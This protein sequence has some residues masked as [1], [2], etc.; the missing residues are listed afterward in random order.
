MLTTTLLLTLLLA[1]PADDVLARVD[2]TPVTASRLVERSKLGAT[3]G[4]IDA[5]ALLEDLV[6]DELLAREGYRQGLDKSAPAVAAF[7]A[8]RL[9]LAAERFLEKDL[10]STIKIDDAQVKAFFHET[11]DAVHLKMIILASEEDA[12]ATLERLLKGAKFADEA[13][14][15]LDPAGAAKQGDYG[16]LSRGQLEGE[17]RTLAFSAPL[18]KPVGPA[19]LPLGV[20]V[21][22][23]ESRTVADEA[24]LPARRAEILSFSQAQARTMVRKHIVENLRAK[25]K[26]VVDQ[27]FLKST[28]N[29]LQATPQEADRVVAKVGSRAVTYGAVLRQQQ[30]S[31]GGATGSHMSGP[32]VKEELA[33]SDVDQYLLE[34]A[35]VAAGYG[36]EPEIL[37]AAKQAERDAVI[38]EL[39]T[40]TRTAVPQPAPAALQAFLEAHAADYTRPATRTCSHLVVKD[41]S[42]AKQLRA[43][44]T[45][46]DRFEEL[47]AEHSLDKASAVRG[48]LLGEL[49]D[50]VLAAL[51]SE[52]G[53]PA[54][55]AAMRAAKPNLVSE[56]VQGARG[57]HL[58][59]CGPVTPPRPLALDDVRPQLTERAW[60]EQR[61]AAVG[62][63][64]TRLRQAAKVSL[65]DAALARAA[66][67]LSAG[68]K[69]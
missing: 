68:G 63:L 28:G 11:G 19:K 54:L 49:D 27:E 37:A 67:A 47:A 8:T 57:W 69:R 46:G 4:P 45:K 41:A 44:L 10:Y 12:K 53:E 65:D 34:D 7:Q 25:Q 48:G 1:A 13:K 14:H 33:W 60:Q 17:A 3:S 20:A 36:K 32:R 5:R 52:G 29:R 6:N 15:S 30:Q 9:R 38:R 59:R 23:V 31:F 24:G 50:R 62:Q 42:E 2:G 43:Q 58:V 66:A 64:I 61:Q 55:A 40:R 56:P 51:G 39:A 22:V 18:G 26:I 16:D 21:L 35:A